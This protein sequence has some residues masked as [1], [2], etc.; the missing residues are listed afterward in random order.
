MKHTI[1]IISVIVMLWCILFTQNASTQKAM[2]R[3]TRNEANYGPTLKAYIARAGF[4]AIPSPSFRHRGEYEDGVDV[5]IGG[6][7]Y[8]GMTQ[9]YCAGP[10]EELEP[11]DEY[12]AALATNGA[13]LN[14]SPRITPGRHPC[15]HPNITDGPNKWE[16]NICGY[17]V[18]LVCLHPNMDTRAYLGLNESPAIVKR[19]EALEAKELD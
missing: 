19:V 16:C 18:E 1:L 2:M 12:L 4:D 6:T 15:S 14:K 10:C 17:A 8:E 11:R 7:T 13:S 9:V 5:T 3:I